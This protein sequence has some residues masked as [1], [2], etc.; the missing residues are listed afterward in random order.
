M[1][2]SAGRRITDAIDHDY[3]AALFIS[4][5]V[6]TALVWSALG[7]A[8]YRR[9]FDT[10]WSNSVLRNASMD[11]VH[12]IV[13]NGLMTIFFF[14]IGL[15]LS[16]ELRS[17]VLAKTSHAL[18]PVL[19]AL[20]GMAGTALLSVVVGVVAHSPALRRGW[21]VPMATDIA[22]TL[23]V[24]AIVGRRLPSTVRLFLLTLAVADDTFSVIVLGFTGAS[25]VREWGLVS[26]ALLIIVAAAITRRTS[27]FSVAL[28]ALVGLWACL[29]WANVEAPL[30]GVAAGL[31][32]SFK[33]DWANRLEL[34]MSRWSTGQVLPFFALVA[35]GVEWHS[36]ALNKAT[37]VVIVGLVGVRIVGKVLGIV[38]GVALARAFKFRLHPSIT[39][40]LLA[41]VS[42]LCAMGITVPLLFAS[43][44]FGAGS[45]TYAADTLGLLLASVIAGMLGVTTLHQLTRHD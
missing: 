28:L 39:W 5:G 38:G 31:L 43:T 34:S 17:G 33:S 29:L 41:G 45:A 25:H 27:R 11:S 6:G 40:P 30:A 8:S 7:P 23:G 18:P 3:S 15:E 44:L 13:L 4:A 20:G 22:F 9:V 12:A 26:F 1:T 36:L 14:A 37:L 32:V 21:G 2:R 42:T 10:T 35:C 16:R 24:V 19:G